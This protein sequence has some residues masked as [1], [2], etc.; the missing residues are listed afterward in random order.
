MLEFVKY[1][2]VT[3]LWRDNNSSLKGVADRVAYEDFRQSE[4]NPL[5]D[6]ECRDE[7][8][9]DGLQAYINSIQGGDV[10][11]VLHQM[12]NHGPAYYKRY[13]EEFEKF[14][15]V[16]KTNQLESCSKEEIDNAYDNAILY[17]DYFLSKVID[18]LEANADEFEADILYISDHGESL[19]ESGV[20]LHGMPYFIA[21]QAQTHVPM[22]MWF[23]NDLGMAEVDVAELKKNIHEEYSHDNIFHTLLGLLEVDISVYDKS[24]DL[25]NSH[26]DAEL[27]TPEKI[28][29]YS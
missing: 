20:Y 21:P 13:P 27:S 26:A 12:G 4:I 11:I 6:V 16:C 1:V 7:G 15:P 17:T 19:G 25:L 3:V 28:I 18:F 9:L 5:C 8:M 14:T 22:I 23:G 2:E 29:I 10:F 24:M